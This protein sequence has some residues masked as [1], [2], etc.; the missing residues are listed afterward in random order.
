VG[1]PYQGDQSA[2]FL[3]VNRNKRGIAVDLK[4]AR[5]RDIALRIADRATSWWKIFGRELRAGWGSA[6]ND[7]SARNPQLIY[8]SISGVWSDRPYCV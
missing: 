5:G 4:T 7:L 6:Y 1:A 2:Y 3:S 8:A